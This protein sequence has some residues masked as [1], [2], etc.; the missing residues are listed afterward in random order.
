MYTAVST[1]AQRTHEALDR[2]LAA[3]G[4]LQVRRLE[5]PL[6]AVLDPKTPPQQLKTAAR[7]LAE[8]VTH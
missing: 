4:Q 6:A 1:Q 3:G 8:T 5:F 2:E 7:N